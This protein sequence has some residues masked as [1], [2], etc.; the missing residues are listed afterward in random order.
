M[1][2]NN[3]KRRLMTRPQ[4][5]AWCCGADGVPR[6]GRFTLRGGSVDAPA[7]VFVSQSAVSCVCEFGVSVQ[8]WPWRRA[9]IEGACC[10][11]GSSFRAPK[12]RH[13]ERNGIDLVSGFKVRTGRNI[14][15]QV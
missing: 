1:R 4:H 14:E 12:G 7:F 9:I 2:E 3:D 11:P 8:I 15:N 13:S 6:T 10:S 5:K